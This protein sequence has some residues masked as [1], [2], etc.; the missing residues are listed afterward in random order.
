MPLGA[1]P[2]A[3]TPVEPSVS[4]WRGSRASAIERGG[5]GHDLE[6][7]AREQR[8]GQRRVGAAQDPG[9]YRRFL[10]PGHEEDDSPSRVQ[11]A[12]RERHPIRRRLGRAVDGQ[13]DAVLLDLRIIREER[14]GVAVGAH[15]AS[16]ASRCV[17]A[18]R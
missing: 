7:V 14:S 3:G 2:C 13:A 15:T 10:G 1:P 4:A 11:L 9:E 17:L 12:Q 18:R 6:R 16:G 5:V 8:G